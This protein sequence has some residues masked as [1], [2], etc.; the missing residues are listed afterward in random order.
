[1]VQSFNRLKIAFVV[2]FAMLVILVLVY[3]LVENDSKGNNPVGVDAS[4]QR[5]IVE[6]S[7]YEEVVTSKASIS[8]DKAVKTVS[9]LIKNKLDAKKP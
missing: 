1:M 6:K 2:I 5:P 7:I 4:K 8:N 9:S 3:K